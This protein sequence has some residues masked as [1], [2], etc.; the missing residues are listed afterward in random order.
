[1]GIY[2]FSILTWDFFVVCIYPFVFAASDPLW[3]EVVKTEG[4]RCQPSP[5]Y[6]AGSRG[7]TS[8]QAWAHS[9]LLSMARRTLPDLPAPHMTHKEISTSLK[10]PGSHADFA[11]EGVTSFL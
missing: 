9:L 8:A 3:N 1:M 2:V 7:Q 11:T 10:S 5:V 4:G 6:A